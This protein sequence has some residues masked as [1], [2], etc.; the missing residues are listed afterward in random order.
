MHVTE[1]DTAAEAFAN[2]LKVNKTLRALK[3]AR[4][5]ITSEGICMIAHG[6]V[7]Q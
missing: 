2:M 1:S 5:G 3:L 4:C 6:I 7:Y